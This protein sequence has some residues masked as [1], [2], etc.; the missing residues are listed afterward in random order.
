MPYIG[1][2][3]GTGTRNRFI[4]TATASQT[5]F[6]GADD[7]G[8]TLKYSD[9]DYVDVYL[10]G[11]CLVPVTDYTS[12]SKTSIVLT[13]AASLN[14]TLEVVAYDIAT[15]SDTVSKADGGTFEGNVT[16]GS[17]ADIITETLGTDN[18]RIGEN[19]GDSIA[20]GG[21]DNV[22]IGKN[23]GT[24]LTTGDSNVAIGHEALAAQ[25]TAGTNTVVGN[26]AGASN[27]SGAIT[28]FGSNALTANT[29]GNYSHAFGESALRSNTTGQSNIAVGGSALRTNTTGDKNIGIG[30]S[31]LRA[32]TTAD[33]NTAVGHHSGENMTT[34][35]QNTLCGSEAGHSLTTGYGNTFIGR[36]SGYFT[37][38]GNLN[39]FVGVGSCG[40]EV[41]TGSNNTILGSYNGNQN[42]LDIR[43]SSNNI[44]LSDG[45]GAA[46][47]H[48]NSNGVLQ[49][50][51]QGVS[52]DSDLSSHGNILTTSLGGGFGAIAFTTNIGNYTSTYTVM[53]FRNGNGNVGNITMAGSSTSYNTSSDYRL[54]EN[55]TDVT[56]G[57]TRVK[58]LSPKR[59]NF[60]S[61]ADTTVDGFL[62]HE[63]ATV[64]PEAV[65]GAKDAMRDEEYQVSAATGDIYTPATEEAEEVIHS[66][67]VEQPETLEE[68][69]FWRETTAAVM[70]TRS[71]PDYQGIDQ[72][73]LVPLLTAALQEAIAKIEDLETRVAAL[74][75]G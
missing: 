25:T 2:S 14:D 21:N 71:V 59:F 11:I 30:D 55:V 39:T 35:Y 63:T 33:N 72:S 69:Q 48:I 12:T 56:D 66:S 75:A 28:A 34:G 19:A 74:E 9:S 68:G 3:P 15:I 67:N 8:K 26:N 38:T 31:S 22:V 50:G 49:L 62:A 65:T 61:D 24:A 16:F 1:N 23:A 53:R 45:G 20:S 4:Y 46:R 47:M 13:Q 60:I 43:T 37:T 6:S 70:D 36:D 51:K 32:V 10:N 41:T 64:V 18:V 29:T 54:K 73:K 27:T 40:Q 58:Q 57:I 44:V 7:N 52:V 17:S 5:T 42:N